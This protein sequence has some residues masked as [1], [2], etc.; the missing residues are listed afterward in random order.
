MSDYGKVAFAI[1]LSAIFGATAYMVATP[2]YSISR[3]TNGSIAKLNTRS[4]A[5][6]VCLVKRVPDS[7]EGLYTMECGKFNEAKEE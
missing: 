7:G 2:K 1:I 5:I 3:L 4:G 6:Q